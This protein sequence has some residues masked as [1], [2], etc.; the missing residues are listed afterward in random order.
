MN[1]FSRKIYIFMNFFSMNF[2]IFMNDFRKN[3]TYFIALPYEHS[4]FII[5]EIIIGG[6]T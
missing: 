5:K 3:L 4:Y 2:Y 6:T 1:D